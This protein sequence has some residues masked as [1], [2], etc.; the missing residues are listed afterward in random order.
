MYEF[1]IDKTTRRSW[2]RKN[3]SSKND[4]VANEL[5]RIGTIC[6]ATAARCAEGCQI[7]KF[8]LVWLGV[9][10][11][12]RALDSALHLSAELLADVR[13]Q[14]RALEKHFYGKAL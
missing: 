12:G 11:A 5:K 4:I 6:S 3:L 13:K 2:T 10:R 1:A 14:L 8:S 9:A 7:A